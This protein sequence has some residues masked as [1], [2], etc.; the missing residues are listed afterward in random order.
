M[1]VVEIE[2]GL[3]AR[4]APSAMLIEDGFPTHLVPCLQFRRHPKGLRAK[5]QSPR[6][7]M[8]ADTRDSPRAASW[9]PTGL[10]SL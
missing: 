8:S 2:R 1:S 6:E 9:D 7:R 3:N 4:W 5:E 10:G